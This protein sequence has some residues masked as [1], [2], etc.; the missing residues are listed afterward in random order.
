MLVVAGAE[1]LLE[2]RPGRLV[3]R[4]PNQITVVAFALGLGGMAVE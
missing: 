2:Y 1:W 4:D 3:G